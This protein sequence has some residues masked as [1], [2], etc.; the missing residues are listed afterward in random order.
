MYTYTLLCT[1][2]ISISLVCCYYYYFWYTFYINIACLSSITKTIIFIFTLW[3]GKYRVLKCLKWAY[4]C[5]PVKCVLR[6]YA[7]EITEFFFLSIQIPTFGVI[8]C[9]NL[10]ILHHSNFNQNVSMV[11]FSCRQIKLLD[12]VRLIFSHVFFFLIFFLFFVLAKLKFLPL[13]TFSSSHNLIET[14]KQVV[15]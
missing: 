8:L 14:A 6:L 10:V 11:R 7:R 15:L 3:C 13:D 1:N 2:P 4:K 12:L 9:I 5:S